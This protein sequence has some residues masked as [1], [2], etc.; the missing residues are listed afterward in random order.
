[1]S[2]YSIL[3]AFGSRLD[4]NSVTGGGAGIGGGGGTSGGGGASGTVVVRGNAKVNAQ[5]AGHGAGIGGGGSASSGSG[6]RGGTVIVHGDANVNAQGAGGGAGVGGGGTPNS[7]MKDGAGGHFAIHGNA[8]VTANSPNG[9][10]GIGGGV[11]AD[12][13]DVT[14]S[15]N[16]TVHASSTSVHTG[17]ADTQAQSIGGGIDFT[18]PGTITI[19]GNP[20]IEVN[21]LAARPLIWLV[22]DVSEV[23]INADISGGVSGTFSVFAKT[24]IG[25]RY[26]NI[27]LNYQW[28]F[29][30]EQYNEDGILIDGAKLNTLD[31]AN[32]PEGFEFN[33]GYQGF[34]AIVTS[35]VVPDFWIRSQTG[36]LFMNEVAEP[37]PAKSPRSL[38]FAL[39][40]VNKIFGDAPYTNPAIPSDGGGAITY[41]SL[42]PEVAAVSPP[43][44]MV[45]ILAAGS[46]VIEA[47]VAEHEGY[48][49]ARASYLLMVHKATQA[50][51]VGL[52]HT[53]ETNIGTKDGAI[54]GVNSAMEWKTA[55]SY[56]Y[57]AVNPGTTNITG[58]AP[59]EY[60]IR[61]AARMNFYPGTRASI[62]ILKYEP[63]K[64]KPPAPE[65]EPEKEKP[66]APEDEPEK[67]K[68]PAPEDEPEDE[69]VPTPSP[70][71]NPSPPPTPP[72]YQSPISEST[73]GAEPSPSPTPARPITV[74]NPAVPRASTASDTSPTVSDS[75]NDQLL[76][77]EAASISIPTAVNGNVRIDPETF[78]AIEVSGIPIAFYN[79]T[80]RVTLS[81]EVIS[82]IVEI[83]RLT[84]NDTG[85]ESSINAT[86]NSNGSITVS[87]TFTVNNVPLAAFASDFSLNLNVSDQDR[88]LGLNHN[89][90]VAMPATPDTRSILG[91]SLNPET[92]IFTLNTNTPGSFTIDYVPNLR[93][94]NM[95]IA[96]YEITDLAGNTPNQTM[97][98]RPMIQSNRTLV[99]VRFIAN[100]LDA[101]AN[102]S[103][104]T[105]QV[106]LT[107][108]HSQP[109]TFVIGETTPA[110]EALGMDTPA[111]IVNERT[112]VPLRFVT[113]YFG[114]IVNWDEASQA[115]EIIWKPPY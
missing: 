100:A 57:T 89:R 56:T 83:L 16:A 32:M 98:V 78:F 12:G 77:E 24:A 69:T 79:E 58:L 13:G 92:G 44:G 76:N 27:G 111:V 59:G 31:L 28:Y 34:Y 67:E 90:V 54:L 5:G 33:L 39:P 110:L 20:T 105:Q 22:E 114:A 41:K 68:T 46:A 72:P 50:A 21:R 85:I 93:R 61:Y 14:I 53:N 11:F 107:P 108:R 74:L 49:S 15:G 65:D 19:S 96:S 82:E 91:G 26:N 52:S 1:M 17:I 81:A 10:A 113:E 80:I 4:A 45:T 88:W 106:T 84:E 18:N 36:T 2:G 64:E 30:S 115:I 94:L 63:E 60:H 109:L 38:I 87:V 104:P 40:G 48:L 103:E 55:E 70:S 3:N 35:N 62:V 71:P 51:P 29:V 6:G 25:D 7:S 42:N 95:S 73:P 37:P 97:D 75:V 102:W 8:K 43:S 101:T 23:P 9:G 47:E 112:F 66:P 99:P 86:K